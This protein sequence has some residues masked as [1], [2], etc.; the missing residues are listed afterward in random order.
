[1]LVGNVAFLFFLKQHVQYVFGRLQALKEPIMNQLA[2]A[3][4]IDRVAAVYKPDAKQHLIVLVGISHIKI[5]VLKI[6]KSF[7]RGVE[8]FDDCRVEL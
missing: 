3:R 4:E 7:R 6:G 5:L 1:M 2:T 8:V